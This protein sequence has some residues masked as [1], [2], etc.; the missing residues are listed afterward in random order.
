MRDCYTALLGPEALRGELSKMLGT[1]P[2]VIGNG[3]ILDHRL[4]FKHRRTAGVMA[5]MEPAP[6]ETVDVMVF[7]LKYY[8]LRRLERRLGYPLWIRRGTYDALIEGKHITRVTAYYVPGREE[9]PGEKLVKQME[10]LY[11][12]NAWDLEKLRRAQDRSGAARCPLRLL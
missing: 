6:G 5:T 7:W 8:E 9:E 1:V 10:Q 4:T 11:R 2:M 3:E 12:E